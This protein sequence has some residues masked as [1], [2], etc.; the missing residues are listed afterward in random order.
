[1]VFNHIQVKL[2]GKELRVMNSIHQAVQMPKDGQPDAG[3][4]KD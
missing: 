1:M 2:F 3:L 4:T